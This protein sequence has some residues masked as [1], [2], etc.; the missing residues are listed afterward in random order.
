MGD[1]GHYAWAICS[2]TYLSCGTTL[3]KV[4]LGII[5]VSL[6]PAVLQILKKRPPAD[7]RKATAE[8]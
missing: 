2:G 1:I 4:L 7:L 5:A 8:R 6:I 3:R